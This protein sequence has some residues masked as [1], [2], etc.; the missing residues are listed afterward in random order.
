[1]LVLHARHDDL[2]RA[3]E[4]RAN[5]A[6]AKRSELVLFERGDHNSIHAYNLTAILEAVARVAG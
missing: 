3:D 6:W 1:M 4:A 5:A 2:V